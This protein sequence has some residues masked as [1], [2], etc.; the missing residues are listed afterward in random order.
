MKKLFVMGAVALTALFLLGSCGKG[1]KNVKLSSNIDSVSYLIGTEIGNDFKTRG[2]EINPEALARGFMDVTDTTREVLIPETDKARIMTAFQQDM[3][4]KQMDEMMKKAE[5]NRAEGQAFLE[6]NKTKPGVKVTPS[7]LQYK[8]VS[9]GTGKMPTSTDSVTVNYKGT[10]INGTVFDNSYDR[11]EP[12]TFI[13]SAV[14]PGWTEGLQLMKEGGKARLFIPS[15]LAYGERHAG[16]NIGPNS[17][18]IFDVEL[19]NI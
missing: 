11:G 4:K 5:K 1:I 7:G 8:I 3:Q 13:L 6:Q 9:E 14:I 19:V 2:I 16:P 10:L 12:A 18:L 15:N 17:T